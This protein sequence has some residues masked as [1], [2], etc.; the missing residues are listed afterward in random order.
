MTVACR[1]GAGPCLTSS[2]LPFGL[3]IISAKVPYAST[4]SLITKSYLLRRPGLIGIDGRKELANFTRRFGAVLGRVSKP[5]DVR[6]R[7]Q[8]TQVQMHNAQEQNVLARG[9]EGTKTVHTL[10]FEMIVLISGFA[11]VTDWQTTATSTAQEQYRRLSP[12]SLLLRSG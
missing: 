3:F 7:M 11:R 12:C 9:C 8:A 4:H 2:I 1:G 5:A 10:P 6:F